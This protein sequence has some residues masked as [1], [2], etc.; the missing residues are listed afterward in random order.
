MRASPKC[1][2]VLIRATMCAAT[3]AVAQDYP[4]ALFA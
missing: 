2:T 3:V 4:P 1:C